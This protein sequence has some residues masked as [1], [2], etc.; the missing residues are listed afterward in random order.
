MRTVGKQGKEAGILTA[1]GLGVGA[2]ALLILSIFGINSL[3][4]NYPS[5]ATTI[6]RYSGA[7]WLLWQAILCFLPKKESVKSH[8]IG[9]F[10]TG[11][12][13]HFINIEMVIFY[14]VVMSQLSSKNIATSL[15]FLLAV[16]MAVFTAIWF[17][18]I[19]QFTVRIPNS[20]KVLNHIITRIIFG[21][22]FLISAA[23]LVNISR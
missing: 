23:A 7:V 12:I 2:F 21:A 18:L 19:A 22:L 6:I 20:E 14:I 16:E 9:S 4:T 11:F 15:Q 13:N 1:M 8:N 17:V 3:F 10:G 5:L